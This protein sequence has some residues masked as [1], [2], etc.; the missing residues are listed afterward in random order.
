MANDHD[1]V[2]GSLAQGSTKLLIS[3]IAA[4]LEARC[5]QQASGQLTLSTADQTWHLYFFMG[6]LL[7]ATGGSHRVRRWQRALKRHCPGFI[8]NKQVQGDPWEYDLLI[9]AVDQQH[10]TIIQARSIIQD[11][12]QEVLFSLMAH[13]VLV[14]QWMPDRQLARQLVLIPIDHL[15]EQVQQLWEQWQAKGL[16]KLDADAVPLL[17]NPQQFQG[18]VSAGVYQ[19]LTVLLDGHN[20]LWDIAQQM[21]WPLPVITHSLLPFIQQGWITLRKI[22]DLPLPVQLPPIRSSYASPVKQ[23]RGDRPVIACIDDSP[24]IAATLERILEPAGFQVITILDPL[25]AMASLLKSR[26]VLIFLDLLMPNTN[27]YELC[28]S[29]RRISLFKD[30]PII[31]LT[32]QD[33]I[34]DRVRAK[35]VGSTD[36][37]AKPPE[38]DKVL[39]VVHKYLEVKAEV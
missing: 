18:Q 39:Q 33:S 11:A 15:T 9:Q 34:V 31:I 2:L 32:G 20:S 13:D 23:P 1:P 29:L 17:K 6:R 19:I 8:P 22:S 35:L 25:N 10:I 27:G 12:A 21:R 30:I 16:R 5:R 38:P 28:A 3:S 36:F 14:G 7:Y 37:M 24:L 4:E 26:P